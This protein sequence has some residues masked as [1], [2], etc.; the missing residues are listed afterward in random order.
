PRVLPDLLE[1]VVEGDQ[2]R[3]CDHP[4]QGSE[5]LALQSWSWTVPQASRNVTTPQMRKPPAVERLV[6]ALSLGNSPV[7]TLPPDRFNCEAK[8]LRYVKAQ[9]VKN[10][11]GLHKITA[12]LFEQ[13]VIPGCIGNVLW[14][15]ERK[16]QSSPGR[17]F[18][19]GRRIQFLAQKQV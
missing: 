1:M 16:E 19:I 8:A 18:Q 7:P 14:H 9:P 3:L 12:A 4:Y 17:S 13:T 10:E 15:V 2:G 5:P 11:P 6:D